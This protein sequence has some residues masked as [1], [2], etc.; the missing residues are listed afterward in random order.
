VTAE[1]SKNPKLTAAIPNGI[2]RPPNRTNT[3]PHSYCTSP[4]AQCPRQRTSPDVRGRNMLITARIVRRTT[5]VRLGGST[6]IRPQIRSTARA[7]SHRRL[8]A[9][10]QGCVAEIAAASKAMPN[11]TRLDPGRPEIAILVDAM[12]RVREVVVSRVLVI[13]TGTRK[14]RLVG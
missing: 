6:P 11:F 2:V 5:W 3:F 1:L 4:L 13:G 10:F 12:L 9:K 8:L 7:Y 14:R